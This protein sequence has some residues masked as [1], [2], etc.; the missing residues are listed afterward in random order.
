MNLNFDIVFCFQRHVRTHTGDKPYQCNFCERSF[1]QS[2]DLVKHK[3][4]H[5][6]TNTYQCDECPE[7]FRLNSELRLHKAQ[8]FLK[9]KKV[10]AQEE[11][12]VTEQIIVETVEEDV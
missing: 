5:V 11:M 7:A 12:M 1:A 8:H 2:N 4:S 10:Q 6:G 3:R 9:N